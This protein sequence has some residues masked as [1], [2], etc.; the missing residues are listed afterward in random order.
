MA[1]YVPG[2]ETYL[3]DIK[4]FT[5]DYKFLSAVLDTRQDKYNTNWQATNDVYNRVVFADLSRGDTSEQREQYVN[6][7][8]PSLEKIA[9]MD[10]SLA[11]NAQSAKA[12]FAPFFEDKLIVKDMVKTA[13][14]RKQ[15]SYA[16]R[17]ERSVDFN[18]RDMWW[19]DGVK[20]L[21][22]R[23]EDF[24]NMSPDEALN[25]K[26]YEYTPDAD[27]GKM[28]DKMLSE[29]EPPLTM[30][31]D[32]FGKEPDVENAD[33]TITKGKVN[34]DWIITT[35][36]GEAITGPALAMI[37]ERLQDDPRVQKAYRTQAYVAGRDFAAEG[38][39]AG[40]F[41][42]VQEGQSAWA[43]ETI[44]RIENNNNKDIITGTKKLAQQK[45]STVRWSNYQQTTGVIPG[46]DD[47]K[48]MNEGQNAFD[49]TSARLQNRM[50]VRDLASGTSP[51]LES[52][53]NKAYQ[54]LQMTNMHGDMLKAAK[55]FSM[56]DMEST[57]RVNQYA[58]QSKQFKY[59][60]AK[61]SATLTER[62]SLAFD[63]QAQKKRDAYDL[64]LLEGKILDPND[65]TLNALGVPVTDF[66]DPG[67][68]VWQD[69]DDVY[70]MSLKSKLADD[71]LNLG[72]QIENIITAS[73]ALN[74]STGSEEITIPVDV[75]KDGATVTENYTISQ[76]R[77]YLNQQTEDE[78]GVKTYTNEGVIQQLWK[79]Y[80]SK[81]KDPE[82]LKQTNIDFT[83]SGSAYK[84]LLAS[85]DNTDNSITNSDLDFKTASKKQHKAYLDSKKLL[86]GN[87]L[88]DVQLSMDAGFG[89][90]WEKGKSGLDTMLTKKEYVAR[91][92][93]KVR[94]NQLTNP[95]LN[96]IDIFGF[97]GPDENYRTKQTLGRDGMN[98]VRKV[99]NSKTLMFHKKD[100][101]GLH[102]TDEDTGIP[103]VQ[104]I[105][106]DRPIDMPK[107]VSR[108]STDEVR[109]EAG[110]I[111]DAL[112]E[113]QNLA[114]K[115]EIGAGEIEVATYDSVK[116]RAGNTVA[117]IQNYAAI[118]LPIDSEVKGK[119]DQLYADMINQIN[120]GKK[121][122]TRPT[123]YITGLENAEKEGPIV[124]ALLDDFGM[125]WY[126]MRSNSKISNNIKE[127]PKGKMV[128]AS[129][130]GDPEN[131]EKTNAAYKF[132]PSPAWQ[133]A[134]VKGGGGDN[135]WAG[136]PKGI[137]DKIIENGITF[138]FDQSVDISEGSR[139][140]QVNNN[141]Q[142]ASL[143]EA[144]DGYYS[145]KVPGEKADPGGSYSFQKINSQNYTLNYEVQAYQPSVNGVG[146]SYSS[147]G[148]FSRQ[149]NINPMGSIYGGNMS[150]LEAMEEDVKKKIAL[151]VSIN[152][153][154]KD[155]DV[156][157]NGKKSK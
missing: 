91:A 29:M 17:L 12:V 92:I 55:A 37:Q 58:K 23:M 35:K 136:L 105:R 22:Y 4:P 72:S 46:S 128:Y 75:I 18:Q 49:A 135:Q 51:D 28:A 69:E 52:N 81:L 100:A 7:L 148:T 106:G 138:T 120:E 140:R 42:S 101:N 130:Y 132:F 150:I 79:N 90:I 142:I 97:N 5:P 83:N 147:L 56:R 156:A 116:R 115:G 80:D 60:M 13:N 85:F 86:S 124:Q 57:M 64:A 25:A 78:N 15:M 134:K 38:M 14:Y 127:T 139:S 67:T 9:G 121:N 31:F 113:Q 50:K 125:D 76:L 126:A 84:N 41:G 19:A 145:K 95:D 152:K 131:P 123:F 65:V 40:A 153:I 155:R 133:I 107:Q 63:L 94:D 88:E 59:D 73:T 24:I 87:S 34:G 10:L 117:D 108:I 30:K 48:I 118:S 44:K 61:L 2:S 99:F 6:N 1:T 146:G 129:V 66:T 16:K 54:L 141:S 11:Q 20:E 26:L 36:N 74:A 62:R 82:A 70:E 89:D 122:G 77:S 111:Y 47:E 104:K 53:L 98:A 143:V 114:L 71:Q 3:P 45:L 154:A 157:V 151:Q 8:A 93:Q 68:T 32:H 144:G 39:Q 33:G 96:G 102:F 103:A 119:G 112:Q 110:E 149:I 27:L 43:T 109:D 137:R 21:Q